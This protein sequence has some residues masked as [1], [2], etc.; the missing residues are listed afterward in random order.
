MARI[1]TGLPVGIAVTAMHELP[2]H[3]FSLAE[4][5]TGFEYDLILPDDFDR[6][7][8]EWIED[9]IRA[10]REAESF[11]VTRESKENRSSRISAL[12]RCPHPG[13]HLPPDTAFRPFRTGRNRPA[14]ELLSSALGITRMPSIESDREDQGAPRRFRGR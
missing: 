4:M 14:A 9:A 8:L 7:E 13:P 5:I 1:N 10:F 3:A 12:R 11:G 2:P 6:A